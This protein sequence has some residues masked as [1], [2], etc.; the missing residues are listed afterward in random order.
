[1]QGLHVVGNQILNGDNIPVKIVGVNRS[2]MEFSCVQSGAFSDGPVDQASINAMLT[3]NIN[4]V[5]IPLNEDCWLGINGANPAGSSYQSSLKTYVDLLT[6]ANLAVILDLH[7]AADGSTK[8]TQQ[9]PMPDASHATDF[10]TS[11][12]TAYSSYTNVIFDL[13]NEPFPCFSGSGMSCSTTNCD[14][15]TTPAWS[16]W[17]NGGSSCPGLSYNAAGMQSMVNA[18]RNTSSKAPLLVNGL[19]YSGCL[20]N[21]IQNKPTDPLNNIIAGAHLYNGH[22]CSDSSCWTSAI[23]PVSQSYPVL[24]GEIGEYDCAT[25]FIVPLMNWADQY[26]ISYVGWTWNTWDCGSGPALISSYTAGTP[27]AFGQ[28]FQ[29]HVLQLTGGNVT[30]SGSSSGTIGTYT[31]FTGPFPPTLIVYDDKLENGFQDYSWGTVN[32]QTSTPVHSGSSSISYAPGAAQSYDALYLHD[33]SGNIDSS[34]YAGIEFWINGGQSGGQSVRMQLVLGTDPA[35]SILVN[36][37]IPG[38]TSIPANTWARAY[39]LS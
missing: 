17:L 27:T 32:Y 6:A 21:W 10:W 16:C 29:T 24:F 20:Y 34:Q 33:G 31:G 35:Q 19:H 30:T 25:S 3:W 38:Y 37:I 26:N 2:G 13:F 28:G 39:I 36:S 11:V 12:A 1:M 9:T 5:R 22:T 4:A 14:S 15:S 7:W 18:V 8:A 23:L